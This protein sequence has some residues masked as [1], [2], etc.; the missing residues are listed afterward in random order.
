MPNR[1]K[2]WVIIQLTQHASNGNGNSNSNTGNNEH[3]TTWQGP[4]AQTRQKATRQWQCHHQLNYVIICQ[5]WV[6]N[7]NGQ[8][9]TGSNWDF[10][11]LAINTQKPK[12]NVLQ[13]QQQQLLLSLLTAKATWNCRTIFGIDRPPAAQS[14]V[15]RAIY[16]VINCAADWIVLGY[17]VNMLPGLTGSWLPCCLATLLP[18]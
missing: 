10:Y 11:L 18:C 5:Q 4:E 3:R 9:A 8:R 16:R 7:S 15:T 12:T 1:I 13:Q 17:F 2:V 14:V 6:C